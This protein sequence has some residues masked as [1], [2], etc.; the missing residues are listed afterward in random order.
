MTYLDT[1]KLSS[2]GRSDDP[3]RVGLPGRGQ[4]TVGVV[5]QLDLLS[6][7]VGDD[8]LQSEVIDRGDRVGSYI[9]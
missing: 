7:V 3:E 9:G 5:D 4:D 1:T 6:T 8:G 2:A